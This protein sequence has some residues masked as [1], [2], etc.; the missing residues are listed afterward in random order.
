MADNLDYAGLGCYGQK[1]ILTPEIDKLISDQVKNE[2][3]R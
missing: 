1:Q 2:I 3:I